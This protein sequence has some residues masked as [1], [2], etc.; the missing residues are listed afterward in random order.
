[1]NYD[2]EYSRRA[3][4]VL[5]TLPGH[6][7]QFVERQLLRL[8]ADPVNLSRPSVFPYPPGTQLYTF[9]YQDPAEADE[10]RF[11]IH[12]VYAEDEKTLRIAAIGH[13]RASSI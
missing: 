6:V 4:D 7:L 8:A 2:L 12:F 9:G 11:S 1:M 10:W 5:A 13:Y 3:E